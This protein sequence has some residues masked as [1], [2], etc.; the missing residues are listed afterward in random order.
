[1][2]DQAPL[3]IIKLLCKSLFVEEILHFGGTRKIED[4]SKQVIKKAN[5]EFIEHNVD[6]WSIIGA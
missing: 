5:V 4:V 2:L 1:M 3:K 6:L